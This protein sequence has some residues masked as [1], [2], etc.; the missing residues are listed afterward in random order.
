MMSC[1]DSTFPQALGNKKA[2]VTWVCQVGM[3]DIRQL[4]FQH[5][6][7]P[8]PGDGQVGFS[9]WTQ[10]ANLKTIA[11][12]HLGERAIFCKIDK[13]ELNISAIELFNKITEVESRLFYGKNVENFHDFLAMVK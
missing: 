13:G 9:N 4:M 6:P 10:V 1:K 3:H 11:S 2:K 7:Q 8:E 5:L 12:H